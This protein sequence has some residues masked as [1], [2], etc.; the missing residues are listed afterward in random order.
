[1]EKHIEKVCKHHGSTQ[2]VYESS[3]NYYRCMKCRVDNVQKRRRKVKDLLIDHLGGKCQ[4]CGYD[5]LRDALEFHHVDD[6]K[7]FGIAAKG[8]TRSLE[9][10]KREVEK[11]ALLCCRCH[12][13]VH[14]GILISPEP[15]HK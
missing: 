12:R 10:A 5:N 8:I 3:R 4:V 11:C 7:E 13:E 15:I 2:F 6:N 14:G 1:M 9:I